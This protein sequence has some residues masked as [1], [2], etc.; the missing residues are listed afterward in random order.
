MVVTSK[1]HDFHSRRPLLLFAWAPKNLTTTARLNAN[2]LTVGSDKSNCRTSHSVHTGSG[3]H[4]ASFTMYSMG[5]FPGGKAA[6]TW[7]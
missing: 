3:A 5:S 7:V 2:S 4:P 1:G 6:G